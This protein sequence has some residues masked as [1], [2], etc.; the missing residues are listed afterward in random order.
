LN[1]NQ[2]FHAG[3]GDGELPIIKYLYCVD[4]WLSPLDTAI[5][6]CWK[7]ISQVSYRLCMT[8]CWRTSLLRP[9]SSKL[10][11]SCPAKDFHTRSLRRAPP[12]LTTPFRCI[13]NVSLN[14]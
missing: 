1:Y 4:H 2:A 9:T 14:I 5:Q 7:L 12:V 11:L 3:W 6:G 10:Y 13:L 8:T